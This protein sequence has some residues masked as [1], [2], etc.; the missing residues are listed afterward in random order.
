MTALPGRASRRLTSIL[1]A[2]VGLAIVGFAWFG[3]RAVAGWR[4]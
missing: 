3:Y 4:H 2:A 1:V